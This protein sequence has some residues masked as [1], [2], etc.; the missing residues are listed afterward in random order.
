MTALTMATSAPVSRDTKLWHRAGPFVLESGVELPAVQVAYRSWGQL[1]PDGGNAVL[2][3]HALT[4]SADADAWW[5]GLY[6]PG[7][8][9]DPARDFI[10]CSNVLAGCYGTSGPIQ[11]H[12]EDGEPWGSRF[13]VVTVRDMVRL[14]AG[15]LDH[16]GVG[17]LQLV[18]GPSLGGM[19]VLEWAASY[20]ER[21]AAIAPIGV[22]GRHSAWCIGISESQRR[23]I[24]L[25]P[26]WRDGRYALDRPPR[27][28]EVYDNSHIMGTNAV[29]AMIVAGPEGFVKN[30]YR[31]FNIR[32]TDITPGDDF[33]MM[34]EVMQRRFSRLVREHAAPDAPVDT[35]G[36]DMEADDDAFPAWPDLI[37][38]DGGQGQ[39]SSVRAILDELGIA[40]HVA[41]IGVAKGVDREAGRERFFLA[42]R[43]PFM[44][45][46]RDPVLYFVQRLRDEAHR[47]AIGSHRA[48]RS[49]EL[50]RNPLDEIA[51]IGPT[52]KRALLHHFG[53]ARAVSRAGVEDLMRVD[54]VSERVARMIYGHFHENG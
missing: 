54:G 32:S 19:Q 12:P 1:A 50:T 20:P 15:L 9:L 27:R 33:G 29:G 44:L 37:L 6:G 30:Q 23:A 25:D 16:L 5:G 14:Q 10:V 53:S 2:V 42:G 11:P 3:C 45:P 52:R 26:E 38:I 31:K 43:E 28:I 51:G 7:R 49:R 13:P 24:Y 40:D 17:R 34:R 35:N 46:V 36:A 4:G 18:L 22:S 47:F 48:R 8:A 39:M 41:A 21:V